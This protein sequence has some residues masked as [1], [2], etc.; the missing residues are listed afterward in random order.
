ME[1]RI[2]KRWVIYSSRNSLG[3]ILGRIHESKQDDPDLDVSK[4]GS[5]NMYHY[6][7]VSG[8]VQGLFKRGVLDSDAKSFA[9]LE[10]DLQRIAHDCQAAFSTEQMRV[11]HSESMRMLMDEYDAIKLEL[12][13]LKKEIAEK[14]KP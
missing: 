11:L 3:V 13:K 6:A 10:Q 2:N 8:A 5:A 7:T 9:E 4:L 1:I 14:K 12:V